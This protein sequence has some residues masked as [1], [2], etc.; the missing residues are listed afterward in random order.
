M[1]EPAAAPSR[2]ELLAF[3]K[4]SGRPLDKRDVARAFKLKGQARIDL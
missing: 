3:I 1:T 4:E 2:D